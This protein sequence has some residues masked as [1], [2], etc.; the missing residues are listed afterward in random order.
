MH[1]DIGKGIQDCVINGV[2]VQW[3]LLVFYNKRFQQLIYMKLTLKNIE[4]KA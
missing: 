1:S 3:K 4:N 2:Y